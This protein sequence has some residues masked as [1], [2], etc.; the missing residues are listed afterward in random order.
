MLRNLDTRYLHAI[1]KEGNA[2]KR[3]N[4]DERKEKE[5]KR[6]PSYVTDKVM[7]FAAR[8]VS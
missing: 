3:E 8:M 7:L 2:P 6:K 1:G 4:G 5:K